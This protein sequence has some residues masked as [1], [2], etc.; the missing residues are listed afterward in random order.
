MHGEAQDR[1]TEFKT[2]L[3]YIVRH[4]LRTQKTKA[5]PKVK[6]WLMWER[7]DARRVCVTCLSS[8]LHAWTCKDGLGF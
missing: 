1:R 5:K 2:I 3:G 6:Y 8:R 7:G 4:Y